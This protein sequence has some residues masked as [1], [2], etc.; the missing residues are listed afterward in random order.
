LL[1]RDARPLFGDDCPSKATSAVDNQYIVDKF[2][3]FFL[4]FASILYEA[5]P[6]VVLGAVLAGIVQ[7]IP[8]RRA[9][10]VMLALSA[11]IVSLFVSPFGL[12]AGHGYV[13]LV[14]VA[15]TVCDW[16]FALALGAAVF[17]GLV[18]MQPAVD[19]SMG[20]LGRRRYLTIVLCGLLGLVIP[21]CECGIIP[22]TR[23]LLRKGLPI[24]CCVTFILSGPI[25][26]VVVLMTTYVAFASREPQPGQA[27]TTGPTAFQMGG[28]MMLGCRA[29][30][31]F[32]TAVVVGFVAERLSRKYGAALLTGMASDKK[33]MGEEEEVREDEADQDFAAL[34]WRKRLGNITDTALHDFV[35]ITVFLIVGALIAA[36]AKVVISP[37]QIEEVSRNR[38]T[39]AIGI[40]MAFA[41]VVT[42]CS[43]ADAFVAANFV[44]LRPAAKLAF[45]VLGPMLDF[46]L[47]FMYTRIFRPRLMW[48]I[49]VCVVVQVFV[50]S[51]VAH[52]LWESGRVNLVGILMVVFVCSYVAVQLW[53]ARA[54]RERTKVSAVEKSEYLS[55]RR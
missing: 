35:D 47:L 46:K 4:N 51:Y 34:P 22:L 6:W 19:H 15:V 26:N 7:E 24:S 53:K 3:N 18:A 28:L 44:T 50:Y 40:M 5:M 55:P 23:R 11:V 16:V 32:I 20:F 42:L 41:F 39:V 12:L 9:P 27:V 49:I 2:H 25:I 48:T 54:D 30:L 52:Q 45:L 29:L 17:A 21:M 13:S 8:P 14:P 33:A 10:A 37:A 38:P 1:E 36:A 43:E 31:G